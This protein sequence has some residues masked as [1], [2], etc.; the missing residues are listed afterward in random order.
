[1]AQQHGVTL[2]SRDAHFRQIN[3]LKLDAW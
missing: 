1:L 2:I 3:N